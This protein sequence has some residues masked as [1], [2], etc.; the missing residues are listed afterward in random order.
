M[1]LQVLQKIQRI[2]V[3]YKKFTP[4]IAYKIWQ[5]H[6]KYL[7]AGTLLGTVKKLKCTDEFQGTGAETFV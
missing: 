4:Q 6:L 1:F 3:E 7:D 5:L 2:H